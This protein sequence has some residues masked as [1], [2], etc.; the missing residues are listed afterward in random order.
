MRS[1]LFPSNLRGADLS[2]VLRT[3]TI[4]L[5]PEDFT[6][7]PSQDDALTLFA[8][9]ICHRLGVA[10][11]FISLLD[12]D[13]QFIL[14]ESSAGIHP[15]EQ[16][17]KEEEQDSDKRSQPL[18]LG[19]V[20]IPRHRG[21]CRAS[22]AIEQ[23]L[24]P[25]VIPDLAA[26][27]DYKD[28]WCVEGYPYWRFYAAYPLYGHQDAI[29]GDVC[30]FDH[31][32]RPGGVTVAETK[33][34][35]GI[36]GT[37][38]KYLNTLRVHRDQVRHERMINGLLSFDVGSSD[39][40]APVSPTPR[41]RYTGQRLDSGTL[42]ALHVP[43]NDTSNL[44]ATAQQ[45]PTTDVQSPA[46]LGSA[47]QTHHLEEQ[48]ADEQS[49]EK[50]T[51]TPKSSDGMKRRSPEASKASFMH[52]RTLMFQRA[53]S[54]LRRACDVDGVAFIDASV[55]AVGIDRHSEGKEIRSFGGAPSAVFS[56]ESPGE[57]KLRPSDL[58]CPVM[59][60]S[61]LNAG[62][63]DTEPRTAETTTFSEI[64]LR[65]IILR[66]PQGQAFEFVP[67]SS[68]SGSATSDTDEEEDGRILIYGRE[69]AERLG[70]AE[71]SDALLGEEI[72]KLG[73]S[74]Q[75][76][77]LLPLWNY[78]S[79][80]WCACAVLWTER[81]DAGL[82]DCMD[83]NYLRTFGNSI[84]LEQ[85]R[86]YAIEVDRIKTSFV[87][88]ISHELRTPLHGLLG[89]AELIKNTSVD[90][91]QSSM[92]DIIQNS[93]NTL[94]DVLEHV[95][96]YSK[97]TRPERSEVTSVRPKTG[98]M[99][100]NETSHDQ[101]REDGDSEDA[102]VAEF[103][104]AR[105]TEEVIDSVVS[106]QAGCH[107][108]VHT[109]GDR[110]HLKHGDSFEKG[111]TSHNH[112]DSTQS[113]GKNRVQMLLRID[114]MTDTTVRFAVGSWRRIVMN[115]V[116][117]A[118]KYTLKGHIL[119]R[120][121]HVKDPA[122]I[123]LSV[124]DTGVGMSE[125]F[126]ADG[127]RNAFTQE[128]SFAPGLGLG[129]HITQ[130]LVS[131]LN[132]IMSI[133]SVKGVGT[134]VTVELASPDLPPSTPHIQSDI[135]A[136]TQRLDGRNICLLHSPAVIGPSGRTN[137]DDTPEKDIIKATLADWFKC[138]PE[139]K[140]LLDE[141]FDIVFCVQVSAD[142]IHRVITAREE[143]PQRLIVFASVT[144]IDEALALQTDT[145]LA[146]WTHIVMPLLHP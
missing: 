88:S 112:L 15:R 30:V 68:I 117:N 23:R 141:D 143:N 94:L 144:N 137:N 35:D 128:D 42:D 103:N 56:S 1:R 27:P 5:T 145:R 4:P 84:M 60:S 122:R 132:G 110:P 54:I 111:P 3:D 102:S 95:L 87:A 99:E 100:L 127:A 134:R 133:S 101:T 82:S 115:L 89:A 70:L 81:A 64:W 28:A 114:P 22:L 79:C 76:F 75:N 38:T 131:S 98:G 92:L 83:F 105:V 59:A 40:P 44:D 50:R 85:S 32:A 129:L 78:D 67:D 104:L 14:A 18:W 106:G 11:A 2:E 80:N 8:Q 113:G 48:H 109:K 6:P 86:L 124:E 41:P 97:I 36:S 52:E 107:R 12:G 58:T 126:M 136:V 96:D 26:H 21:F 130:Q 16:E 62:G 90:L 65:R 140:E 24:S 138:K 19:N 17:G 108:P 63:A 146:K 10:R 119:V 74:I 46:T 47:E 123:R 139:I 118:L 142:D 69:R 25:L 71:A 33:F 57:D 116:S 91:F 20:C 120:L 31:K 66:Y 73:R 7:R 39:R 51:Q 37:I 135:Y 43:S 9:T 93:G 77:V 13:N 29:V 55:A 49:P 34:L 121:E 45:R 72:R 53:A 125:T 61:V